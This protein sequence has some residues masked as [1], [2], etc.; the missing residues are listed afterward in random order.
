M[1]LGFKY[2]D[3]R[4]HITSNIFFYLKETHEENLLDGA[5]RASNIKV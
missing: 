3:K 4:I 2:S 1:I 5:R